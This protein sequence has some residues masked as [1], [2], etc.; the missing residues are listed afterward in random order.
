MK[1]TQRGYTG[2]STVVAEGT[3]G[4]APFSAIR[5]NIGEP[6]EETY[7][8]SMEDRRDHFYEV[9][10]DRPETIKVVQQLM[11][12]LLKISRQPGETP[13]DR[14]TREAEIRAKIEGM[15]K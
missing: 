6:L 13:N 7:W 4:P 14:Q 10:M 8:I 3:L 12:N 2:P 5:R 15:L 1:I 11:V 9:E